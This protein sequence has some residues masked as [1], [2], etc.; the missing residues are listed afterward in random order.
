M[1]AILAYAIGFGCKTF[2]NN[3]PW[4]DCKLGDFGV[5]E[6]EA[7]TKAILEYNSL[8]PGGRGSVVRRYASTQ[9]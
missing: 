8:L 1:I 3:G 6:F 4:V 7:K 9:S 5:R 2:A